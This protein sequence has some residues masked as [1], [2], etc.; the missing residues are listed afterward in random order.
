VAFLSESFSCREEDEGAGQRE[1]RNGSLMLR[2]TAYIRGLVILGL[3]GSIIHLMLPL[4]LSGETVRI[5]TSDS[6]LD[7]KP[8]LV[9]F[10]LT[11]VA[12]SLLDTSAYFH[13]HKTRTSFVQ[14]KILLTFNGPTIH[15]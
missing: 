8:Q 1:E 2:R 14:L 5:L 11:S 7:A 4:F 13:D 12:R 3:L 10:S 6:R 15:I 9:L